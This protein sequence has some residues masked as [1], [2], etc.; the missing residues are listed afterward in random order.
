MILAWAFGNKGPRNSRLIYN[1]DD[2]FNCHNSCQTR[3]DTYFSCL[4]SDQEDCTPYKRY[5]NWKD[6]T[7]VWINRFGFYCDDGCD[8]GNGGCGAVV[9][10]MIIAATFVI[11]YKRRS[12]SANCQRFCFVDKIVDLI[13]AVF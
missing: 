6:V 8:E 4:N 11:R 5:N 9:A 12:A 13:P 2:V 1:E 10:A 3:W 7:C